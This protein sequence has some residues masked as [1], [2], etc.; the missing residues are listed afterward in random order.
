MK[1][2]EATKCPKCKGR[3][4]EDKGKMTLYYSSGRMRTGINADS[5]DADKMDEF[6][7]YR[8]LVPP[9]KYGYRT[10]YSITPEQAKVD[11]TDYLRR[12]VLEPCSF[13]KGKKLV[14]KENLLMM[15]LRGEV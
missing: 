7:V 14:N 1:K 10:R 11:A 8:K 2:S 12:K 4:W 6:S 13:C 9:S 5:E 3:G 15:I